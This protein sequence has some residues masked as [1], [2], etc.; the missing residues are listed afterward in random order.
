MQKDYFKKY[1]I[2]KNKYLRLK[3]IQVQIGGKYFENMY[4]EKTLG[5][6]THG[7]VYL[8][9]DSKTNEKYAMKVEQIF[10]KDV[11]E[12]T[13]SPIWREIDFA[14]IMSGKYPDQFM[15]IYK[16]KNEKC[17]YTRDLTSEQWKTMSQA[18]TNYYKELF[19]SP[20]C[21]I[22]LTS[23]VDDM[24]HNIIYKLS[25]KKIIMDL[26]IQV[27]HIAYLI[28]KEGYFHR[29]LHPKNIGIINTKKKNIKI[30][31][32]NI[33]THGYLLQAIDYGL[34]IHGKYQ[35]E[36]YELN[37]LKYDNYLH[38]SF[39]KIIF[40]IMLKNLIDKYPSININ[41]IVPIS[42]EDAKK[43]EPCLKNILVDD[44]KYIKDSYDFFQELLY[45]IIF[46]DKFQEQIGVKVELFDF[47]PI[48]EVEY[49][50]K[51]YHNI[52]KILRHF[53]KKY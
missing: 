9:K 4:I 28:N 30:L 26:F 32:K 3:N 24:L 19:S 53:I 12:S 1:L 11:K 22:K 2:Y 47:I 34:V 39:Y 15:K 14:E 43:L 42:K 29:D 49:F 21:S 27:V 7:T 31:D 20:Y 23:I 5:V 41:Q 6:G 36:E 51:N 46:F 40:K 50:V 17:N 25:D 44:S 16:Y 10:E 48:S 35:L 18:A 8:V 38:Q 33:P 37:A 13:K 45:K 52:Y